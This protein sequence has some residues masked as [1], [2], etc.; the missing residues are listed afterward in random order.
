MISHPRY[1]RFPGLDVSTY[2]VAIRHKHISC[3][4]TKSLK[5]ISEYG[6]GFII[7]RGD[8]SVRRVNRVKQSGLHGWIHTTSIKSYKILTRYELPDEFC[9]KNRKYIP[10]NSLII[11]RVGKI[12]LGDLAISKRREILSDCLLGITFSDPALPIQILHSINSDFH[13][14]RNLY[15]GTGAPYITHSKVS[16]YIE[17][18]LAG[19]VTMPE[20]VLS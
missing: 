15:T 8:I 13:S 11:P 10:K 19:L 16:R 20:S 14:F 6:K 17:N 9:V 1:N 3:E 5:S 12:Q 7:S 4:S 2:L 18:L